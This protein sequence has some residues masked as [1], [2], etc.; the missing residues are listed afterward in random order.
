MGKVRGHLRFAVSYRHSDTVYQG[1]LGLRDKAGLESSTGS[2]R[3]LCDALA[4]VR[5]RIRGK[6]GSR[7]RGKLSV[8]SLSAFPF[9]L[10]FLCCHLL[11]LPCLPLCPPPPLFPPSLIPPRCFPTL[12]LSFPLLYPSLRFL[13]LPS[14]FLFLSCPSTS[15]SF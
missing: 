12:S 6:G 8:A 2:P 14:F 5:R 1:S 13:H 7:T 15:L 9:L 11:S 4:Q 3:Y 10:F